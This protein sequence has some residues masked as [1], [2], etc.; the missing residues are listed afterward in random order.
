MIGGSFRAHNWGKIS[1]KIDDPAS[2]LNAQFEGK[3]FT[4]SDEIYQ[5]QEMPTHSREK[6]HVLQTVD[7]EA[8][9]FAKEKNKEGVEIYKGETRKDHDYAVSWI[10]KYGNGRV[11]YTLFG[12]RDETYQT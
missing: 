5:Y 3:N 11:F 7:L 1:V 9:G 12:H 4:F 8:S 10:K 2:P 6:M